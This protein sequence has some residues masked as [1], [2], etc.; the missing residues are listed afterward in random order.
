VKNLSFQ[1]TNDDVYFDDS[2]YVIE[3]KSEN[4]LPLWFLNGITSLGLLPTPF[5]KYEKAL[6]K[7]IDYRGK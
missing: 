6:V 3:A 7:A 4:S 5:P 2:K 1:N